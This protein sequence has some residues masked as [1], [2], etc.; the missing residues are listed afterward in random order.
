MP[1]FIDLT[2]QRFGRL[3]V[4]KRATN[5]GKQ[6]VWECECECGNTTFVQAGHLRSGTIVSCGCYRKENSTNKA[7]VHGKW[8]SKLHMVW[9]TMRQRC[10]N[11]KCKSYRNYGSRGISVC[12]E[13]DD[14]S[15]F[16]NWAL[17]NGYAEGLTI[18]RINVNGNYC[19]ENCTWIPRSEQARNTT[20]TLNN[21]HLFK[22]D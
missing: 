18:E 12:A 16:E 22:K 13:W 20:R 19:P 17:H 14:F 10:K 15:T 6:T 7:T 2:N 3:K 9:L 5:N 8:G 21:R 4:I 11:P 1:R